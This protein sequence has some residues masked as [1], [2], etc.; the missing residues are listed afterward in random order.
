M[1]TFSDW[2]TE[3]IRQMG[4]MGGS[5]RLAMY[6]GVILMVAAPCYRFVLPAAARVAVERTTRQQDVLLAE[7]AARLD[8]MDAQLVE[9]HQALVR[10]YQA[11]RKWDGASLLSERLDRT[12]SGDVML[13]S[14]QTMRESS[15]MQQGRF[16]VRMR[17][18]P[19]DIARSL[20]ALRSEVPPARVCELRLTPSNRQPGELAA[21]VVMELLTPKLATAR[22]DSERGKVSLSRGL[23]ASSARVA[24]TDF[25]LNVI[26]RPHFDVGVSEDSTQS[27]LDAAAPTIEMALV[28]YRLV[29]IIQG[30]DPEA[31]I[32]EVGAGKTHYR[33]VGQYLGEI[34]IVD[35]DATGV[36]VRLNN[37]EGRLE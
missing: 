19:G 18:A 8:A 28:G 14:I 12:A 34:E 2:T 26:D 25:S 24:G 11:S 32:R 1:R 16:R 13:E 17:G 21:V 20:D 15:S 22:D 4:A 30:A 5:E 35:I 9:Q 36:T 27:S 37:E 29:G 31:L 3:W 7:H 23:R 33:K 6:V 10:G